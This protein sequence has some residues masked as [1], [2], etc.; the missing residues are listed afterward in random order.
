MNLFISKI[1]GALAGKL[2]CI[3]IDYRYAGVTT[4]AITYHLPHS[5]VVGF[6]NNQNSH[7]L[8]IDFLQKHFS[9]LRVVQ[10]GFWTN[11]EQLKL[12]TFD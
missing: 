12:P 10:Q 4:G 9:P 6:I 11:V 7:I 1:R 2:I 5:N 3:Y 8:L